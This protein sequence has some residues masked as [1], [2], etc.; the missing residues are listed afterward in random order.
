M[1]LEHNAPL[2]GRAEILIHAP[3]EK[4]WLVLTD[5][6]RWPDWQ[7]G[8]LS[9]ELNSPLKTGAVIHWK[10]RGMNIVSTVAEIELKRRIVWRGNS[11]GMRAAHIWDLEPVE[12]ATRV[13]TRETISGW[14]AWVLKILSPR[15][16]DKSL[17]DSLHALKKQAEQP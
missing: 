15:F 10:A 1:D 4:V 5:I 7:P 14:L 16:L 2:S 11:P 17:D 3:P 12:N 6:A 13:A 9:A 8:V